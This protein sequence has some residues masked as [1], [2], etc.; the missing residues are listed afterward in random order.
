MPTASSVARNATPPLPSSHNYRNH[1]KSA[2]PRLD[3][4]GLPSLAAA[5]ALPRVCA[6]MLFSQ[7][8]T[9]CLSKVWAASKHTATLSCPGRKCQAHVALS[10]KDYD[11]RGRL[12]APFR[13]SA[14]PYGCALPQL[15]VQAGGGDWPSC[16][17]GWLSCEHY[18]MSQKPPART[19]TAGA[20][21]A[22]PGRA[23][24]GLPR[25]LA[26]LCHRKQ[27][28]TEKNKIQVLP[29]RRN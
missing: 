7:A 23:A 12:S 1:L 27:Q 14:H 15:A 16:R 3:A 29:A 19:A 4:T 10:R 28:A 9:A 17:D 2:S 13:G 11:I 18:V 6:A 8:P 21:Q 24:T 5:N 22:C 25:Q 20:T 26:G